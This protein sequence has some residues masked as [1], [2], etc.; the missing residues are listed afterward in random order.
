MNPNVVVVLLADMCRT[1]MEI[2]EKGKVYTSVP[3]NG[4]FFIGFA[5]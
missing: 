5:C 4:Q 1:K 3:V 2:D